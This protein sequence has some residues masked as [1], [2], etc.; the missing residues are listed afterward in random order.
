MEKD[1]L[2]TVLENMKK[3]YSKDIWP[4]E[5]ELHQMLFQSNQTYVDY[6]KHL[7]LSEIFE[8]QVKKTPQKIALVFGEKKWTYQELNQSANQ[9]AHYLQ[10]QGVKAENLIGISMERSVELIVGMLAILKVGGTIVPIDPRYPA[11]RVNYMLQETKISILLTQTVL[12]DQLANKE[13]PILCVDEEW[14]RIADCSG[15]NLINKR[16]GNDLAYILFTSGSTGKPKGIEIVHH[17]ISRLINGMPG[18]SITSEDVFLQM[19]S[20][21][22]AASTIEIWG[23]LLH[24]ACL[25]IMP[26]PET[27]S[28]SQLTQCLKEYDVTFLSLPMGLFN[29]LVDNEFHAVQHLKTIL[30]SGDVASVNHIKKARRIEGLQLI[31]GYGLTENSTFTCYYPIPSDW[32]GDTFVPVGRPLPDVEVYILD[33]NCKPVPRGVIGELAV[34]GD[35]LSRGYL[36]Q[37]H[38]THEKFIPHPFKSG[39]RLCR[40]GDLA[41][42]LPD[43]TIELRGRSD[44]LVKVRGFRVELGEV[45][46]A[47]RKN[48]AVKNAVVIPLEDQTR[49]KYLA[50]YVVT[51]SPE[52]L[53]EIR[54]DLKTKLPDYMIPSAF[55]WM[56]SLPLNPNGKINRRALPEPA[57]CV[58]IEAEYVP[59]RN[60]VEKILVEAW[61]QVLERGH[62]SIHDNFFD[63]GGESLKAIQVSNHLKKDN[64]IMEIKDIFEYPTI[65]ELSSHV[66]ESPL[67][68]DEETLS[69]TDPSAASVSIQPYDPVSSPQKGVYFMQQLDP[70]GVHYNI[71]SGMWLEGDL[72][73]SQLEVSFQQLIQRHEALRTSFELI[74]GEPVQKI[75]PEVDFTL[76]Y[77]VMSEE[78]IQA[79]M[80]NFVQP[81]SLDRAPLLRVELIKVAKEKH[82]LLMDLH[83]I[84]SDATSL[85]IMLHE[86]AQ[87]YNGRVLPELNHKHQQRVSDKMKPQEE[88]WLEQFSGELPVLELPTDYS[89]PQVQDFSG[90]R[91]FFR[92]DRETTLALKETMQQTGTITLYMALLAAYNVLLYKYTNQTDIIVGTPVVGRSNADVSSMMGMFVNT[93]GMRMEPH[94][95]KTIFQ[96]VKEVKD[97]VLKAVENQDYPFEELVEKLNIDRDLSRNPLFNT[98]FSVQNVGDLTSLQM[99]GLTVKPV[100]LPVSVAKFDLTFMGKEKENEIEFYLEYSTAL[101]KRE[102]VERLARHFVQVVKEMAHHPQK[103]LAEVEIL[104]EA[105]KKQILVEW[106]ETNR[107]FPQKP[108]HILFEE[109]VEK[110]PDHIAIVIEEEKMTYRE[111]NERANRL[112]RT[113]RKRGVHPNER[114]ALIMERSLDMIV[115]I[116]SILKAG[117]AYVPVDTE[118]PAERI[119]YILNDSGAKWVLSQTSVMER[120][121]T[122]DFTGEWLNVADE[123]EHDDDASNLTLANGPNDLAYVTYTSGTTGR[124]KGVMV[125]HIGVPNLITN[126]TDLF[127]LE[128]RDRIG[129]FSSISFDV[130]VEEMWTALLNGIPLVLIPKKIILDHVVFQKYIYHQ[131][132]TILHLPPAYVKYL[133]PERLPSVRKLIVTGDRSTPDLVQKWGSVY[134]NGYGPTEATVFTSLWSDVRKSEP[135]STVPIGKPIANTSIYILND[136]LQPQPVGVPGELYISGIGLARGYLNQPVLTQEKFIPNPFIPGERMYKT[137]D[138]VRW[139]PDGNIEFIGR[140]D[141]QVKVRGY[142]IEQGEIESVLLQHPLVKDTTVMDHL[143]PHGDVYLC[144]YVVT[145]E[146]VDQVEM[147]EY[148]GKKL[149]KYM[150]PSFIIQVDEIPLTTNGKVDRKALSKVEDLNLSI[151]EETPP[152]TEMEEKLVKIWKEI[153]GVK[154]IGVTRN[155][156]T[157]G[158]HSL[159]AITLVSRIRQ[160]LEIHLPLR[161]VFQHST[162]RGLAKVLSDGRKTIQPMTLL[163]SPKEKKVFCFPPGIGYGVAFSDMSELIDSYAIYAFDYVDA[164]DRLDRYVDLILQVQKEGPYVL[165]GYSAGGPLAFEVAKKMEQYGYTVSDVIMLESLPRTEY[166]YKTEYEIERETKE[167]VEYYTSRPKFRAYFDEATKHELL[168][169]MVKYSKYLYQLKNTGSIQATIHQ[170]KS[171]LV[172]ENVDQ[173]ASMTPDYHVYQ[174]VGKH[175]EMLLKPNIPDNANIVRD[176]LGGEDT[177]R[178]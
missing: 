90:E 163:N 111:L 46:R 49:K 98:M 157:S 28:L 83:H 102:T 132:V 143:D 168:S 109:Q 55:L 8:Q 59:P 36:N 134:I 141:H 92:I 97:Q 89:R 140:M 42:W 130:S 160:E 5:A 3:K 118:Y 38:L 138:L 25:A 177:G 112:A 34:G 56:E 123:R 40:T 41:R 93:L 52:D 19:A 104:T 133:Q 147:K 95:E 12:K 106:N 79:R 17:G 51:T 7:S 43:G 1:S 81:F 175:D 73:V 88:Y 76:S 105:E 13:I 57:E 129:L 16:K 60:R 124:P 96:F 10:D 75:A 54:D 161:L 69:G 108:I 149:P 115:G 62:I 164:D 72:D 68:K 159:K 94:G 64:L 171:E 150:I 50:A 31:N 65:A 173:W 158:G 91:I 87:L 126:S 48:S 30:I 15:M 154:N 39:E 71:P 18:V 121:S 156:F 166:V 119:A 53:K 74:D 162:I 151:G 58:S 14:K 146:E 47:I 165:I 145:D 117:G 86:L 172:M 32:Q 107:A 174:G 178:D 136:Q 127:N 20:A 84:V 77:Q 122:Q 137:G 100:E 110:T 155:F 114:V 44:H 70:K 142:R 139:L 152:Q 148:L 6:P 113:L 125:E 11:E 63:L 24:G 170:I 29:L 27:P 35:G 9:L 85:E 101:F 78:N 33:Q 66:V 169:S 37:P 67:P 120:V 144:A 176:I 26:P 135:L 80:E 153:L 22:F 131:Q 103:T 4:S 99:E 21:A 2:S 116:L 61:Q 128:H 167:Y 82:L 23:S 45:E